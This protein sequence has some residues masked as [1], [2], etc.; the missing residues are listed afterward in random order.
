MEWSYLGLW[1]LLAMKQ[2]RNPFYR[3]YGRKYYW[4]VME[5]A[6]KGSEYK[7]RK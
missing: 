5:V 2:Y 6:L 4:K 7:H 1:D 3:V